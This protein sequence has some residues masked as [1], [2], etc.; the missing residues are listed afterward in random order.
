M[1]IFFSFCDRMTFATPAN[2][3]WHHILGEF[4][5]ASFTSQ[6]LASG[7]AL[8]PPNQEPSKPPQPDPVAAPGNPELDQGQPGAEG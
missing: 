3:T 2:K 4:Q 8:A 1:S 7:H 5:Y 6:E